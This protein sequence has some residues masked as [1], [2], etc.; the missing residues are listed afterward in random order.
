MRSVEALLIDSANGKP[1]SLLEKMVKMYERDVDMQKLKLQLQLLQ[2]AIKSVPLD[3]IRIR[4]VTRI[5]TI[6]DVFNKESSLKKFLTEIHKLLKLYLMI[7]VTTASS[8]RSFSA[9]K[10]VKTYLRSSMTQN[11]LNHCMLLH[12]HKDKTQKLDLRQLAEEFVKV[13][14]TRFGFFGVF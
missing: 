11:R 5:Q 9:L 13:N 1:V 7:P 10:H 2:D 12:V 4:E 3:G 8:E 6:C 14:D